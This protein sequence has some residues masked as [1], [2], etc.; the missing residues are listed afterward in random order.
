MIN[1]IK[2]IDIATTAYKA[3]D[4][5]HGSATDTVGNTNHVSSSSNA[6]VSLALVIPASLANKRLDQALS[7]LLPQ[8]S[9]TL[10]QHWIKGGY[11]SVN[12]KVVT[13]QRTLVVAAQTVT[14]NAVLATQHSAALAQNITLNVVYADA[15]IIVINK[16]PGLVVHPGAGC[17]DG[18]LLNALLHYDK[19]LSQLPRAGIV[20]RLDKDTS[21]LLVVAR[22]LMAHKKLV[23]D[24]E[25]RNIK[26]EY[27]AVVCGVIIS[28]GTIDAALGRHKTKRTLMA[29]VDGGQ[30][31]TAI[32]HYRVIKR[33]AH[34]T[35][36]RLILETGRTHQIRVHLAH[37]NHPI[38]GDPTYG[39]RLKWPRNSSVEL[40][41]FLTTFRRQALHA[42]RLSF[43][44]PRS[45]QLM[46]F[47]APLPSDMQQLIRL[48]VLAK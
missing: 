40:R 5:S 32:T 33:F 25:Q 36:L 19:T 17:H 46:E 30:G 28:G 9:R 18:T 10:L 22:N 14:I 38:V 31:R 7:E 27:E 6:N 45:G 34:Y 13:Q 12:N 39:G 29:V 3:T 11:V 44:H 15:D 24:L 41:D 42:A 20:H 48:L 26:R 4:T 47:A 35:H 8:Y 43:A 21:G 37:I 1:V 2:T 23:D 16:Q